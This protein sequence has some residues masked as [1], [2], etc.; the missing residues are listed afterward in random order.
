MVFCTQSDWRRRL[1]APNGTMRVTVGEEGNGLSL[2]KSGLVGT[3]AKKNA[4]EWSGGP[5]GKSD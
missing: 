4:K 1:A 2:Q 3:V 5:R